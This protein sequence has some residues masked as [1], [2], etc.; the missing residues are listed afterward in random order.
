MDTL[1]LAG[2]EL[3]REGR[4]AIVL[5]RPAGL[6]TT[7]LLLDR[8]EPVA[9][10]RAIDR[11]PWRWR[12]GGD[13]PGR[14][15]G[16]RRL[17]FDDGFVLTVHR[18]LPAAPLPQQAVLPLV[19]ELWRSS[20]TLED[21][22]RSPQGEPAL[23]YLAM[24][25]AR[26]LLRNPRQIAELDAEMQRVHDWDLVW[27]LARVVGVHE[28][29]Q[30]YVGHDQKVSLKAG[31]GAL[32]RF[33]PLAWRAARLARRRRRGRRLWDAVLGEPWHRAITRCRFDGL[34]LLAGPG[35]FLPRHLSEPTP[36][37]AAERLAGIEHP[38]VVDVGTGCGAIALAVA[39]REPSARVLGLDFDPSAL[40]WA[41]RNARDLGMSS[42]QFA[43][44]SLLDALPSELRG[45]VDVVVANVPCVPAGDFEGAAD[46][47]SGAYVGEGP[48]GL[49][50]QRRLAE[51]ALLYLRPGGWLM[52]QLQ[53]AQWPTY[54]RVVDDLGY[55]VDGAYGDGVA[56][57]ASARKPPGN[58]TAAVG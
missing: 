34:E 49:G 8:S 11:L 37:F 5:S 22:L 6:P 25:A 13:G 21:G 36:A 48:D 27:S 45:N 17:T 42:V 12:A 7:E 29:L 58:G 10:F 32:A 16:S 30:G 50:L 3:A 56:V 28:T 14:S 4:E 19:E 44:S 1:S 54:R 20:A 43:H 2:R 38:V 35:V 47:P 40:E 55:E 46:A 26:G 9:A 24:Q 15:S 57:I 33:R 23:V 52:V 41:A 31:P 51:Q 18:A 53:P 39:R